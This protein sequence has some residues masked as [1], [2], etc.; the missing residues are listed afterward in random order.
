M[1]I[2]LEEL[3]EAYG[4]EYI[5][6][7]IDISQNIQ[8]E[9]WFTAVNPNG[10]IPAIVDHD[11]KDLGV[12]E[13]NAILSYLTRRYDKEHRF[14]FA[15]NYNDYTRAEAWI[16]WQQGEDLGPIVGRADSVLCSAPETIFWGIKRYVGETEGLCEILD[17]QL[18]DS[19][20]VVGP[21]RG[22]YSIA[23]IAL[24]G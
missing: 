8:K 5:W 24:I 19:D 10:C 22:L 1:D 13:G 20:W 11:N 18:K 6:H 7:G 15:L 21:D 12:F 2:L 23:D 16:V 9:P 17:T 3:E 14:S 4:L